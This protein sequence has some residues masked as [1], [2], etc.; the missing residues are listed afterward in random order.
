MSPS[1][2]EFIA[3]HEAEPIEVSVR[4][5]LSPELEVVRRLGGGSRVAVFLARDP[6][7]QRLVAVKVLLPARARQ[8]KA[9]A[10]FFR[11]ARA[12]A[13]ISHPNVVALYRIGTL[14]GN[15]PYVVMRYI[16]GHSLA[17]RLAEHGPLPAA[18]GLAILEGVAAALEAA[19]A[20]DILHRDLNPSNVLL[21]ETSGQALLT[22]F[23]LALLLENG[24]DADDRLTTQG[25]VVGNLRY[26]SPEQ[27][28][29]AEPSARAD[30]WG[31]GVLA[32]EVLTG[33]GPFDAAGLRDQVQ[34]SLA[35]EP[36][37]LAVERP[38]LPAPTVAM[39]AR[40]LAKDP[41]ARVDAAELARFLGARTRRPGTDGSRERS[42]ATD[43]RPRVDV[44]PVEAV[45]S[46]GEGVHELRALGGLD[47]RGP[48]GSAV[49]A[50]LSQPKRSALLVYL[51][52]QACEP[53][54][55]RDSLVGLFWSELD[56]ERGRHALRQALYVLRQG[57]GPDVLLAHGDDDVRVDAARLRSDV[58]MFERA[59]AAGDARGALGWYGGDL[60]PGFYVSDAIEFERWLDRE[61]LRLR[62]TAADCAW[63]LSGQ[64]E[65]SGDFI[66]AARRARQATD[67]TPFDEAA[68]HRLLSLLD[69][70]GD[71][72][73]AIRAFA[74]FEKR[75]EEEYAAKPSP[76]TLDLIRHVRG[77]S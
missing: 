29:G 72:A 30:I 54:V 58:G 5:A 39:L 38:D 11:E 61:R 10:R 49:S 66:E 2:P 64:A 57:L 67:L 41:A 52:A 68:L 71:R 17:E 24:G 28:R 51:A 35:S 15:V 19:H 46:M 70:L 20:R 7:L 22:D 65:E 31:F 21:D 16:R 74:H 40:C 45:P 25:R 62:S 12:V 34:A 75:L 13:R 53:P 73:G 48:D 14:P 18:E 26:L 47:L 43:R 37:D 6:A 3:G 56:Q 63:T 23:G 55:R 69:R 32:W 9:R 33:R 59:A 8:E 4:A 42:S 1:P 36:A 77:R 60:L 50:I 76:E 27:L 44:G